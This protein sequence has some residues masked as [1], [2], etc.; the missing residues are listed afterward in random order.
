MKKYTYSKGEKLTGVRV[1]QVW[2]KEDLLQNNSK[3]S[4]AHPGLKKIF[5]SENKSHKKEDRNYVRSIKNLILSATDL[6]IVFIDT[7]IKTEN[8]RI[9]KSMA[10]LTDR[11]IFLDITAIV[12]ITNLAGCRCKFI[13]PPYD[14]FINDFITEVYL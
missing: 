2:L 10:F 12:A 14:D 11:K 13:Q 3:P 8:G 1:N 4:S 5:I 9:I 7:E 6:F